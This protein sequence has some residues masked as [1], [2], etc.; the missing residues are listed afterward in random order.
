MIERFPIY[1]LAR[2]V[3][4]VRGTY[5]PRRVR[6]DSPLTANVRYGYAWLVFTPLDG[7]RLLKGGNRVAGVAGQA[8]A[9]ASKGNVGAPARPAASWLSTW[10]PAATSRAGVAGYSDGDVRASGAFRPTS[11]TT[12]HCGTPRRSWGRIST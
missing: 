1:I 10:T 4:D 11:G 9:W 3:D 8:A 7:K 5:R 2:S 6:V 12:G